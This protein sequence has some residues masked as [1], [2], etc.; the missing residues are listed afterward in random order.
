VHLDAR[1]LAVPPKGKI[2]QAWIIHPNEKP[3]PEPTFTVSQSGQASVAIQAIA[4][5]G[6]VVAVTIEPQGGSKAPTTNPVL[7]ATLN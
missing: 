1:N 4:D 2:Y 6:D 3:I 7:V 5:K